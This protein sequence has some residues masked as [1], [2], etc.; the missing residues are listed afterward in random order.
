[1]TFSV[2]LSVI[3]LVISI[4]TFFFT[5][6]TN[7]NNTNVNINNVRNLIRETEF[8]LTKDIMKLIEK[9]RSNKISVDDVNN[10][11]TLVKIAE[12]LNSSFYIIKNR[13]T[14]PWYI[15]SNSFLNEYNQILSE[16]NEIKLIISQA[17]VDFGKGDSKNLKMSIDLLK[18]RVLGNSNKN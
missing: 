2:F 12:S 10:I 18:N 1:M 13:N 17:D 14:L 8:L 5:V 16:M 6:K 3:S 7:W 11:E 9:I 4:L 15:N